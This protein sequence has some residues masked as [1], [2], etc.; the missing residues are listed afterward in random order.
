MGSKDKRKKISERINLGNGRFKENE[1]DTLLDIISNFGEYKNRDNTK[2]E[3]Y[4][5]WSSDGKFT[6]TIERNFSFDED[7]DGI[8]ISER[9]NQKDD[10]GDESSSVIEHRL[11]RDIL[12]NLINLKNK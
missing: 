6:R 4:K 8:F 9:Y 12:N 1:L 10:D 3:S 5:T 11:A 2:R 7:D